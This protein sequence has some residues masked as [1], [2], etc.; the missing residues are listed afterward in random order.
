MCAIYIYTESY[1]KHNDNNVVLEM[2]AL[3]LFK[4]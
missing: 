2:A 1:H 3:T 4:L